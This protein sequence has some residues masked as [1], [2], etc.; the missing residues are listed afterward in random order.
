MIIFVGAGVAGLTAVRQ[1][2]AAESDVTLVTAGRFGHDAIAAGNTA[3]AQGGIAAALGPDDTPASHATDTIQAGAGLVIP[4][5]AQLVATDG[6]KQ[7][8]DLLAAGFSADRNADGALAF[9][10][11]AA[12]SKSRVVH[13]GEDS[14]GAALSG[15]LTNLVQHHVETG[16]VRLI[17]Q[18][19]LQH[20]HTQT[21]RISGVTVCS[22]DGFRRLSADAVI[23][24][25]G[26]FAGLYANTSSA[27]A[28][29]GQGMLVAARAGAVLAD[30]EFVQFHPTVVPGTGQLISEAVRGAGAVLRDSTGHRFMSAVHPG[31]E[32]ALRDVVSRASAQ[33]M[34]DFQAT[35][36]WLDATVIEQR[37]G[38]GILAAR[39]P[40]LTE[41]LAALG[42]DWAAEY[43]PVAP[44]AHYCM[45]GVATDT[46]G[47]SSVAGL[48]AAGEVASTGFHGANRL[49]SNSLLEG[50][51]FGTRAAEAAR[52]DLR[53]D[54]WE[55]E[56]EFTQFIATATDI[57]SP[58]LPSDDSPQQLRDLQLLADAHLGITRNGHDLES[59]LTQLNTVGHPLAD[60]VRVMATAAL[61][62]PESRGGHWRADFPSQD[63]A[64]ARRAAWRLATS[65]QAMQPALTNTT[66]ETLVHADT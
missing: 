21:G 53:Y 65:T 66:Q 24:A 20:I 45:G 33:V 40:V 26:G 60:L 42:F 5:V 16:A 49:A 9:G 59:L 61:Q 31:A 2:V 46:A 44:A 27:A 34:R 47:R 52:R 37:H 10:L 38:S 19:T 36:V 28:I 14:T 63:P 51:V 64:L 8:Q 58:P 4:E 22:P 50:L 35:S 3:L 39:F 15:F 62:R 6:A 57:P 32:L 11:E 29:T 41:A 56:A 1:L 43:V 30:M 54:S 23:L 17:E 7:V 13:A 55:P 25:T 18:A 48:Y 12:R